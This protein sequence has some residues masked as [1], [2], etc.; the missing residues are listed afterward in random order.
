MDPGME[1][2]KKWKA[3][4]TLLKTVIKKDLINMNITEYKFAELRGKV[5][6]KN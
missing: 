6:C 4:Y 1:W 3:K 2:I 5:D